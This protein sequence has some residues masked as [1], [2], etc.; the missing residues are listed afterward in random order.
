MPLHKSSSKK[1]L[2][3]EN[4]LD[5][6]TAVMEALRTEGYR[7]DGAENGKDALRILGTSDLPN[8]ILLDLMMPIMDGWEF[9]RLQLKDPRFQSIPVV[10]FTAITESNEKIADLKPVQI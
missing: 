7:V 8:L 6:R 9:R 1:I 2:V 10:I 5:V 3:I 4:S